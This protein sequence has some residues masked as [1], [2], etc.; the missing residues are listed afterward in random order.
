LPAFAAPGPEARR[1]YFGKRVPHG[2]I[3]QK[4]RPRPGRGIPRR[5]P[6]AWNG[7]IF[8]FRVKDCIDELTK[9]RPEIAASV[10]AGRGEGNLFM[11]AAGKFAEV[12]SLSVD[13]ASWRPPM[14]CHGPAA[15]W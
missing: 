11:P 5:G 4:A 6:Y 13:Y 10:D 15:E 3:R 2:A 12:E 8:A 1:S 7:G 14:R 9:N